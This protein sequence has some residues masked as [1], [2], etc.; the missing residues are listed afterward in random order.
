MTITVQY[1][2]TNKANSAF[3]PFGVDKLVII[4]AFA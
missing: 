2:S 1:R 4:Y 3:N